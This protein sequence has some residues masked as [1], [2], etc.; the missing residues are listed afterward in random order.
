MKYNYFAN[1]HTFDEGR[2][3]Y[4]NL[5]NLHHPDHGGD[6][7]TMQDINTEWAYFQADDARNTQRTRQAEAHA[8]GRKTAADFH[9]LDEVT[10]VLRVKL[11]SLLN[12]SPDL[13]VE[14]CG[15]WIWVTGDTKTHHAAIKAAGLR[16]APEK[17]AWYF[18]AVPSYN[19]TKR[20]L[21][22]IRN[23]HGSQV[24]TRGSKHTAEEETPQALNA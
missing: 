8:Q 12:I 4:K 15:L 1:C 7:R 17:Q 23:M 21:D 6:T 19:R 9:D 16:Y 24:Y 18:A 3:H 22:E 20:S 14:I 2:A 13:V 10:E 5:A 11:E